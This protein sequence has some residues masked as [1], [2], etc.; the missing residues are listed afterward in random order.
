MALRKSKRVAR[1]TRKKLYGA[2]AAAHAASKGY[3]TG[4]KKPK[5]KGKRKGPM[6]NPVIYTKQKFLTSLWVGSAAFGAIIGWLTSKTNI[7]G[8]QLAPKSGAGKEITIALTTIV[9]GMIVGKKYHK[10]R[11]WLAIGTSSALAVAGSKIGAGSTMG[12]G[13]AASINNM[14]G[15][16][17][18]GSAAPATPATPGTTP[19]ATPTATP[20]SQPATKGYE[21]GYSTQGYSTQGY[22]TQGRP[23]GEHATVNANRELTWGA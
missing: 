20:A 13:L 11:K 4:S 18:P 2:A 12:L 19:T 22:S 10:A 17:T 15:A 21:Q 16:V 7:P 9:A 8:G 23:I 14:L 6:G 3:S 5:R 1:K